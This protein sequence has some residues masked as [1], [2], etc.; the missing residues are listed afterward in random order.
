MGRDAEHLLVVGK[1][2]KLREDVL[3]LGTAQAWKDGHLLGGK[4]GV[5]RGQSSGGRVRTRGIEGCRLSSGRLIASPVAGDGSGRQ[6]TAAHDAT[7][8]HHRGGS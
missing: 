3:A 4:G 7:H 5:G 8:C 1:V 6:A 2:W